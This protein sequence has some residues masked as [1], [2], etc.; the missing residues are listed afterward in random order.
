MDKEKLK[1]QIAIM[2]AYIVVSIDKIVPFI[3]K[4][5]EKQEIPKGYKVENIKFFGQDI[6]KLVSYETYQNKHNLYIFII[7]NSMNYYKLNDYCY[8]EI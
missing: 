5:K 8:A 3:D 4:K 6:K 7:N 1:E 2:K